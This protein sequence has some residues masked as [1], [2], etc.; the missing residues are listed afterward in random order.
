[1][2][3]GWSRIA[4]P[5]NRQQALVHTAS[6]E[7]K[8]CETYIGEYV[9][10]RQP[11]SGHRDR[12]FFVQRVLRAEHRADGGDNVLVGDALAPVERVLLSVDRAGLR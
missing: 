12:A 11:L 4:T 1:M 3:F 9:V 5:N 7:R 2:W 8:T 6:N 10:N